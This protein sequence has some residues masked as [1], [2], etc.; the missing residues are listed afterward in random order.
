[1][2]NFLC[3]KNTHHQ[4]GPGASV[5][6]LL[7]RI[8]YRDTK[9]RPDKREFLFNEDQSEATGKSSCGAYYSLLD[10][11]GGVCATYGNMVLQRRQGKQ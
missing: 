8:L 5:R 11:D 7:R 6:L 4:V 9:I 2:Q 3:V 1:M 10:F